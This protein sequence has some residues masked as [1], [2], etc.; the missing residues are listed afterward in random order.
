MHY[1]AKEIG[2]A[3]SVGFYPGLLRASQKVSGCFAKRDLNGWV[4]PLGLEGCKRGGVVGKEG[5]GGPLPF[6][7]GPE[8]AQL[9]ELLHKLLL[10]KREF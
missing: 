2:P 4:L 10:S 6:A 5:V 1:P 3:V 9:S 7:D 8:C